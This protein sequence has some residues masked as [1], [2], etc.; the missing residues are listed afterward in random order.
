MTRANCTV[1]IFNGSMTNY[2]AGALTVLRAEAATNLAINSI[3][4]I[5][6]GSISVDVGYCSPVNVSNHYIYNR[7]LS[8]AEVLQNFNALRGRFGI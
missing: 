2:T 7:V 4:G 6:L 5:T 1:S 8:D 3:G